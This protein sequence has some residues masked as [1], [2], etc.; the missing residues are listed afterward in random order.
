MRR[1]G[2]GRPRLHRKRSNDSGITTSRIDASPR[3]NAAPRTSATGR[4][5]AL[6]ERQLGGR[7]ELVGDRAD[8]RLHHPAVAIGRARAGPPAGAGR[9]R[10]SPRRRSRTATAA[11]TNPRSRPGRRRRSPRGRPPGSA[12]ADASGSSGRSVTIEPLSGPTFEAS[13]PPLAHTK[14]CGVSVMT[15]PFVHP[16]DPLRVAQDQLDLAGVAVPSLGERDRLGPRLDGRR[17]RR[18]RPRPSRRPSG[19]RRGRRPRGPGWPRASP[20]SAATISCGRSSP[21]TTSGMPSRAMTSIRDGSRR[22][23]AGAGSATERAQRGLGGE[24]VGGGVDVEG[25]GRL[26][27]HEPRARPPRRPRA[28]ASRLPMP[29][30]G[31]ITSGGASSSAFVPAPWRSADEGHEPAGWSRRRPPCSCRRRRASPAPTDARRRPRSRRPAGP[32]AGRAPRLRRA[33]RPRTAPPRSPRS[34]PAPAPPARSRRGDPRAP[35]ASPSIVTTIVPAM[36]RGVA[37]RDQRPAQQLGRRAPAAPPRRGRRRAG[38]WPSPGR[39]SGRAPT[40]ARGRRQRAA[41]TGE[42]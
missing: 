23:F 34:G 6:A 41:S 1:I 37:G 7:G 16:D 26:E 38:S 9:T 4:P 40:C 13:I 24:Q 21:G 31:A 28:W 35:A 11:R 32:P 10:R 14:P 29:N 30:A 5:D 42:S 19:S 36:R 25:Q 15:T 22:G 20:R 3:V 2:P 17:D 39:E 8:G 18:S 27:L 12:R 33:R